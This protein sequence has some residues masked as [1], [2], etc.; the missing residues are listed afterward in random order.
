MFTFAWLCLP[1]LLSLVIVKN[2][3]FDVFFSSAKE[4]NKPDFADKYDLVFSCI[5]IYC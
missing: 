1:H 2:S 4:Q 3:D 5:A